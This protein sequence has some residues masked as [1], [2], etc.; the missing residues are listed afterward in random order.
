MP[1]QIGC[2]HC[3]KVVKTL[4]Q[5]AFLEP[6]DAEHST[7]VLRTRYCVLI[8]IVATILVLVVS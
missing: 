2:R 3:K 6:V 7:V 5:A 8:A 1:P 4:K